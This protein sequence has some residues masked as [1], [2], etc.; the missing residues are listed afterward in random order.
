MDKDFYTLIETLPRRAGFPGVTAA[1][2]RHGTKPVVS[3]SGR[4]DTEADSAMTPAHRMLAGSVGKTFTA[5]VAVALEREGRLGLDDRVAAWLG[6]ELWFGRLANA[7]TITLRHLLSHRAGVP[8]HRESSA[9]AAALRRALTAEPPDREVHL[10][11]ETL[12][13]YVLDQ[14]PLFAPGAGY[15]YSETGYILAGLVIER[16]GGEPYYDQA[17]KRFLEPLELRDT[18]PADRRDLADLAQGY[19]GENDFALRE[20]MLDGGSLVVNPAT[21]WTGGGFVSAAPDLARWVYRLY[22]GEALSSP[23]YLDDMLAGHEFERSA[24]G[25]VAYGLGTYIRQSRQH[26]THY[27]HGGEAPGYRSVAYYFPDPDTAIALQIN[28]SIV[29]AA[30]VQAL[31]GLVA[32][33]LF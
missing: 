9:F 10:R 19:V 30:Q 27:G 8:D 13:G 28:S 11:P 31:L 22:R 33:S 17:R 12:I 7:D 6:D 26:G 25:S 23:D 16:A 2:V 18:E 15:Q 20:H 5:A 14:S 29:P 4:A 1:F 21:E 24:G 32:E 3:A